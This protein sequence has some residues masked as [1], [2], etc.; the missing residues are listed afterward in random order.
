MSKKKLNFQ[1]IV[2]MKRFSML[3]T[4]MLYSSD[5]DLL[6]KKLHHAT[7]VSSGATGSKNECQCS[8]FVLFP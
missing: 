6:Y 8:V 4:E 3:N 5:L 7:L 1:N 2:P